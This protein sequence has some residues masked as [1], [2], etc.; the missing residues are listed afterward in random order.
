MK[1]KIFKQPKF[2]KVLDTRSVLNHVNDITVIKK[3]LSDMMT[4]TNNT[5]FTIVLV[6]DYT[7]F[8]S[9]QNQINDKG[10]CCVRF[11]SL[12][13]DQWKANKQ[14]N[15]LIK[16]GVT[17][18]VATKKAFIKL[19]HLF[20]LDVKLNIYCFINP[21]RLTLRLADSYDGSFCFHYLPGIP[22]SARARDAIIYYLR[23][24][25]F[26]RSIN[27]YCSMT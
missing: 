21:D 9:L 19:I 4:L 24:S 11:T 1:Y 14:I 5:D 12:P 26:S 18:I 6:R 10:G 13:S 22:A 17:H 3:G 15:D 20:D 2:T 23:Y 25:D 27:Q 7:A 16:E 8:D